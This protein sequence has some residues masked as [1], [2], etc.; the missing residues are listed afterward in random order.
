MEKSND[1]NLYQKKTSKKL[2][3]KESLSSLNNFLQQKENF[4]KIIEQKNFSKNLKNKT[5][6]KLINS[7]LKTLFTNQDIFFYDY[8]RFDIHKFLNNL[9]YSNI[10]YST[11][12][13]KKTENI[14]FKNNNINKNN[15]WIT[16]INFISNNTENNKEN[17]SNGKIDEFNYSSKLYKNDYKNCGIYRYVPNNSEKDNNF[18][19]NYYE[20]FF[21]IF[22][23]KN[24]KKNIS[25][26]NKY[27]EIFLKQIDLLTGEKSGKLDI[28]NNKPQIN[29]QQI[30]IRDNNKINNN[31]NNREFSNSHE[32]IG[33]IIFLIYFFN[34][35]LRYRCG[36]KK[37]QQ[38]LYTN[39]KI[40]RK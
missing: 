28:I 27:S 34:N 5:N 1:K 31:T 32:K 38:Y 29:N 30:S 20:A 2:N 6:D 13:Q 33:I 21:T 3:K 4:K 7:S 36:H 10:N 35:F 25:E 22:K 26:K 40:F 24:D 39:R 15:L 17:N 14:N 23:N 18:Q 16:I 9:I 19:Q 8:K 11:S 12:S 37:Q